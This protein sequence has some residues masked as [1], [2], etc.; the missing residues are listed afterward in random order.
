MGEQ[1]AHGVAGTAA[2]LLTCENRTDGS[3]TG[4][5]A[6]GDVQVDASYYERGRASGYLSKDEAVALVLGRVGFR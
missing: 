6:Q 3:L 1:P 4:D 5:P 2:Q